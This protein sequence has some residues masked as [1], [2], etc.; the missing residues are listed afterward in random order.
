LM[1]WD[2]KNPWAKWYEINSTHPL[3]GK[4][5]MALDHVEIEEDEGS[6]KGLGSFLLDAVINMLP[7]ALAIG[8]FIRTSLIKEIGFI[9]FIKGNPLYIVILGVSMLLRYYYSYGKGY[10]ERT[11]EEL[12][13]RDDAS[14][15]K[16]IPTVLKGKVIG[17]GI[18]G[19]FYSEDLV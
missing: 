2:L 16:G 19:L 6:T 7:Y 8:V 18:P 1:K 14:P 4:R 12:L 17:K 3:T 11:I 13:S 5:I 15:I 9:D 10:E